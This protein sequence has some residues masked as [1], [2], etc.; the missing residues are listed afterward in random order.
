MVFR[1][2]TRV[3]KFPLPTA[4][5]QH[6]LVGHFAHAI[7]GYGADGAVQFLKPFV[8]IHQ[9]RTRYQLCRIFDVA[10][11]ARVCEQRGVWTGLH[12]RGGA[13]GVVQVDMGDDDVFDVFRHAPGLRQRLH[14]PWH[15]MR[16][17]VFHEGRFPALHE[18]ERCRVARKEIV[19]IN[20]DRFRHEPVLQYVVAT[21]RVR[22]RA[23]IQSNWSN[24]QRSCSTLFRSF[25]SIGG[26]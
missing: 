8:A 2:A 14:E 12:Q 7:G 10:S 22:T 15:G 20:H 1:V 6:L 4:P 13:A 19:A 21:W 26:A 5:L 9:P 3:Q 18:Q 16:R 11:S 25:V 17:V 24:G 23:S